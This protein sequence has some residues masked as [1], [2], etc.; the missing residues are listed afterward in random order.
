MTTADAVQRHRDLCRQYVDQLRAS[1]EAA[2]AELRSGR[3]IGH[4]ESAA[5]EG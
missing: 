1:G 3:W 2:G 4:R 5:T